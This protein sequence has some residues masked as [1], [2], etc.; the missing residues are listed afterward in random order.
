MQES[1]VIM[2]DI[3]GHTLEWETIATPW[4]SIEP[5]SG[6]EY[7]AAAA[8]RAETTVKITMRYIAGLS[9]AHRLVS[10]GK[11]YDIQAILNTDGRNRELILMCT[12]MDG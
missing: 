2:D 6:K 1:T 5:V 10:G 4:A 3:G 9:T 8:V 7:F 12:E 11:V